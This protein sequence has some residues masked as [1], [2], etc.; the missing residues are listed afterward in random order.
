MRHLGLLLSAGL[1]LLA[2]LPASFM[3]A[4]TTYYVDDERTASPGMVK[5]A[6]P[7]PTSRRYLVALELT[8]GKCAVSRIDAQNRTMDRLEGQVATFENRLR[9]GESLLITCS[10]AAR[11]PY[12]VRIGSPPLATR[13]ATRVLLLATAAIGLVLQA[14][15]RPSKLKTQITSRRRLTFIA[16]ALVSGLI[17]YSVVHEL[18]HYVF[19]TMFGGRVR[20]AVW[21]VFEGDEPHVSFASLPPGAGVW[22]QAGGVLLPTALGVVIILLWLALRRRLS[23]LGHTLMLTP[24]CIL[25]T[26]NL[27]L[28]AADDQHLIGL[29]GPA[30]V[31]VPLLSIALLALVAKLL[32]K[33]IRCGKG[34]A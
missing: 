26:G 13:P 7:G 29:M 3:P 30:T 6:P 27:G 5:Y 8:S 9:R 15:S 21:T 34:T 12:R 22:M 1:G 16:T 32:R 23:W 18:G 31:T 19:G 20:E 24:A 25:L 10:E 2:L 11:G 4:S 17:M 33:A 14:A 28:L